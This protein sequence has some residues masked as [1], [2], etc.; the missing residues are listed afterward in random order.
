MYGPWW[1]QSICLSEHAPNVHKGEQL[2]MHA[3]AATE[4]NVHLTMW[5][6]HQLCQRLHGPSSNVATVHEQLRVM[7]APGTI[8][9]QISNVCCASIG[10]SRSGWY[11]LGVNTIPGANVAR[12]T[13]AEEGIAGFQMDAHCRW[14]CTLWRQPAS[15]RSIP[16][17][18]ATAT[19]AGP[20]KASGCPDWAGTPSGAPSPEIM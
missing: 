19:V 20:S 12:P 3:A 4:L 17:R 10:H 8:G 1:R 5:Y 16:N 2:I 14:A 9:S 18:L 13:I 11:I 6:A 15:A 7:I